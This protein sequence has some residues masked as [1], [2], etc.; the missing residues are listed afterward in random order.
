MAITLGVYDLFAFT[1]PGILY[2]YIANEFL[3]LFGLAHIE[4]QQINNIISAVLIMTV[5]YILAQIL[6]LPARNW[7]RWRQIGESPAKAIEKLKTNHPNTKIDFSTQ[8]WSFLLY[9]LIRR[10]HLESATAIDRDGALSMMLRN[11]SFGLLLYAL[12][13]FVSFLLNGYL[14]EHL[15]FTLLAF[16]SALSAKRK[17]QMYNQWFYDSIYE[18]GLSHGS[19]VDKIIKK[20]Q[21]SE[22][23][24]S[25]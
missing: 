18:I 23:K 1:I 10:Y 21:A 5:G 11:I 4:F 25:N 3:K 17:S 16:V 7:R 14:V 13:Q 6:E 22:P 8:D 9:G 19:S 15:V 24:G 20:T 12:F 2:L